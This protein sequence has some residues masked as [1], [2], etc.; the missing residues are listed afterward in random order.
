MPNWSYIISIRGS[1]VKLSGVLAGASAEEVEAQ[2]KATSSNVP[3]ARAVL[4]IAPTIE[5]VR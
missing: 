2:L 4:R 3:W 5:E 1:A